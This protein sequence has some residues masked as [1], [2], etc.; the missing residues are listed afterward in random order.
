M[1]LKA[2]TSLGREKYIQAL[3]DTG[4]EANLIRA[5]LFKKDEMRPSASPLSLRTADGS[6][7]SGG[8]RK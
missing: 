6:V 2:T 5:G 7:M 4:A 3:I 1:I 8:H